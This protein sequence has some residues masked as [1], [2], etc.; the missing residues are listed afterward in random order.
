MECGDTWRISQDGQ[1]WTCLVA[2]GLGH[3]SMAANAARAAA[4]ALEGDPVGAPATIMQRADV[5]MRGTRGGA[6][7][8]AQIDYG[9]NLVRYAGIGNISATLVALGTTRGL[10]SHNGI[11]GHNAHRIQE[12]EYPLGQNGILVMFSDGLQSRWQ[13]SSY[14]GLSS[15][16]PA[17]IAALLFRDFQRGRDDVTVLVISSPGGWTC[18]QI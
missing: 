7:A 6:V 1:R 5:H 14:A 16:H 17:V 11:V 10:F 2:D 4:S 9:T 13:L 8:I 12:L 18:S 15:R 3:G